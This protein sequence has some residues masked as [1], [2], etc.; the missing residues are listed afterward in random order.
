MN[1]ALPPFVINAE[2]R[3]TDFELSVHGNNFK[4]VLRSAHMPVTAEEYLR[5]T[6]LYLIYTTL[7]LAALFGIVQFSG[8]EL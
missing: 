2:K 8:F 3:L 7:M 4:K 6:R 5:T 1:L